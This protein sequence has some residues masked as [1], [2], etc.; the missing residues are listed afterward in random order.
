M[1][2]NTQE[3]ERDQQQEAAKEPA[4]ATDFN[5]QRRKLAISYTRALK[6]YSFLLTIISLFIAFIIL[7]SGVTILYEDF[8]TTNIS[9]NPLIVIGIF[10]TTGFIIINLAEMPVAFYLHS[11]LSRKYG[12]SKLTNRKWVVRNLKGQIIGFIIAFPIIEGFYWILRVDPETWWFWATLAVVGFTLIMSYLVPILLLP[13]FYKFNPL[14]ETHP[15]L[16]V[17]L[18][19]MT[20][21]L[22]IKTTNAY[23][24]QLGEVSTG[25]NAGFL[26][27]GNTRR[28]IIAD[29]ML[30]Q[31]TTD[32]IKWIL[33]HEIGHFKH[34]DLWKQLIIGSFSTLLTFFLTKQI[35]VP[36][37][38]FFGYSTVV[39]DI[40]GIPVLGLSFWIINTVLINVPS[41]WYSRRMERMTDKFASTII[42]NPTSV[43]SLFIK[44]ADQNLADIDPPWWEKLFFMSH[45][46]I[47][48][49]IESAESMHKFS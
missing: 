7:L 29:T 16:A 12:L 42:P 38:T 33:A 34:H 20:D 47:R 36:L 44:M 24:W 3:K 11:K 21:K 8:L 49:R 45:P 17:E 15:N 43:K 46:P 30:G 4:I 9:Q 39:G 22:E 14:E 26:G 19:Q 25:G 41:L 18:V 23:N 48:E 6:R 28:I 13:R 27:I 35:F 10:F 37:A 32:E 2:P 40:S 5:P 31:Y 1:D